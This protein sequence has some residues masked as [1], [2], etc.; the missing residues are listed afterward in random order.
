MNTRNRFGDK[1]YVYLK[2]GELYFSKQPA[3][4]TTILGSCVSATFFHRS[5]RLAGICHAV[6]P[7]CRNP[8]GCRGEC[9]VAGRYAVCAVKAMIR[10]M[11]CDEMRFKDIEVKL[12]GGATM[13]A[14][15]HPGS[16]SNGMGR[17]N[18]ISAMETISSNGLILKVADV[19][20]ALGRKIIFDT[21]TGAVLLK[22]LRPAIELEAASKV[23][24]K[25]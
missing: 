25:R 16:G 12:F 4:V 17:K 14:G 6:Q 7:R 13:M 11:V 10:R 15:P 5:T 3:V 2:P 8:V 24:D 1:P 19:G 9:R 18:V 21:A 22:R 20:G 23:G